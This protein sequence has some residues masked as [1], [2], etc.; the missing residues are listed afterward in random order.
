M[1]LVV[2]IQNLLCVKLIHQA[3]EQK[4]AQPIVWRSLD[5]GGPRM[6]RDTVRLRI[7]SKS[8][9]RQRVLPLRMYLF[10]MQSSRGLS[11]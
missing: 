11:N 5:S 7:W 8:L 1:L 2:Q 10:P 4:I 6:R 9:P 3:R